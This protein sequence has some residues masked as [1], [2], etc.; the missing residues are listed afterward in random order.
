MKDINDTKTILNAS[1]KERD[2]L[3]LQKL[4]VL[5]QYIRDH[6]ENQPQAFV[7]MALDRDGETMGVVSC[8]MVMDQLSVIAQGWDRLMQTAEDGI[9]AARGTER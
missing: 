7:F 9:S 8:G 4:M 3:C 6:A 1:V 2:V 5:S